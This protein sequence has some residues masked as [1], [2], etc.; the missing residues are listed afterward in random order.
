MS[1]VVN[2]MTFDVIEHANTP[3]YDP[4][5]WL[6]NPDLSKVRNSPK[7]YWYVKNNE[8]L[9]M[10]GEIKKKLDDA[11]LGR[12][13][14]EAVQQIEAETREHM[15]QGFEFPAQSGKK[16]ALSN[17]DRMMLQGIIALGIESIQYPIMIKEVGG[18]TR[19]LLSKNDVASLVHSDIIYRLRVKKTEDEFKTRVMESLSA[20]QVRKA[21]D[22][23]RF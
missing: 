11:D 20:D 23:R 5:I 16:I 6:I 14:A 22:V 3:E 8:I 7:K 21:V 19:R 15:T 2:R 12:I 9:E 17:D 4:S 18:G 10:D 13:K 1:T